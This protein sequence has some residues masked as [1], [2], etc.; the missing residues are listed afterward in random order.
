MDRALD[1]IRQP[2]PEETGDHNV[3]ADGEPDEKAD[4]ARNEQ[5]R[6]SNGPHRITAKRIADEQ[7]IDGSIELLDDTASQQ[8]QGEQHYALGNGALSK[9]MFSRYLLHEP[10]FRSVRRTPFA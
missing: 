2:L 8:G 5:G 7:Q 4:Q 1:I 9:I 3:H 10:P 6:Y